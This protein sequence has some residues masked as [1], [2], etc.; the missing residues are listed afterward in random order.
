MPA[1]L[2]WAH[3]SWAAR[4]PP[5]FLQHLCVGESFD[6]A[7]LMMKGP[8]GGDGFQGWD[9]F[10]LYS[11][12]AK[13]WGCGAGCIGR[14]LRGMRVGLGE[15]RP[16]L[17][18]EQAGALGSQCLNRNAGAASLAEGRTACLCGNSAAR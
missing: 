4:T 10:A 11:D 12:G 3:I 2:P 6:T 13:G 15:V 18:G 7:W 16:V 8:E 14:P 1:A 5:I 17:W 9:E